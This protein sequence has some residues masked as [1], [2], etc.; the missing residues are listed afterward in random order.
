MTKTQNRQTFE[1]TLISNNK[2]YYVYVL[3]SILPIK[4]K[5]MVKIGKTERK[6]DIRKK[7]I[8]SNNPFPMKVVAV[9]HVS[10]Q[11]AE[12]LQIEDNIQGLFKDFKTRKDL[13]HHEWFTFN[14]IYFQNVV[15]PKIDNYVKVHCKV[16]ELPK[17][18]QSMAAP[19]ILTD[20]EYAY[21]AEKRIRLLKKGNLELWELA[22]LQKVEMRI[23]ASEKADREDGQIQLRIKQLKQKAYKEKKAK[24]QRAFHY[25]VYCLK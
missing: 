25:L 2:P 12:A 13:P 22:E 11:N 7:E 6:A 21:L 18:S 23:K 20:P 14:T 15:M 16:R 1:R 10:N 19:V 3:R 24:E 8:E 5:Y 9:H 17:I 4:G